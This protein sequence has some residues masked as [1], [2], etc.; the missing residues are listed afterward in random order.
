MSKQYMSYY[1]H[2]IFSPLVIALLVHSKKNKNKKTIKH[3]KHS[4]FSKHAQFSLS[5]LTLYQT[6]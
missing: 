3:K 4:Y 5:V 6:L 1:K 2:L